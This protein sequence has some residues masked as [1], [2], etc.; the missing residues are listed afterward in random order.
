MMIPPGARPS[1]LARPPTMPIPRR[2]SAIPMMEVEAS[3]KDDMPTEIKSILHSTSDV[4]PP[5][6]KL[7]S[8]SEG[9]PPESVDKL[10]WRNHFVRPFYA[11]LAEH[12]SIVE[13]DS[14]SLNSQRPHVVS[15]CLDTVLP[16]LPNFVAHQVPGLLGTLFIFLTPSEYPKNEQ[17]EQPFYDIASA[18]P[19]KAKRQKIRPTKST[20]NIKLESRESSVDAGGASNESS[21]K[22][23]ISPNNVA[24]SGLKLKLK[25]LSPAASPAGSPL[26]SSP[27]LTASRDE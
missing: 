12:S 26:A 19:P 7:I 10:T 2:V 3:T 25:V 6:S 9:L 21:R 14:G 5:L 27:P 15:S 20:S 11:S 1:H 4:D 13:D 23:S 24:S 16:F 22:S 17:M 8:M 18:G